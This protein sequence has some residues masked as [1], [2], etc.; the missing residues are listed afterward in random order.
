M[1][2]YLEDIIVHSLD[3]SLFSS[4]IPPNFMMPPPT[5][6]A[7]SDLDFSCKLSQDSNHIA[8]IK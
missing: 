1:V 5:D 8:S 6:I 3:E 7:E 4:D 2:W